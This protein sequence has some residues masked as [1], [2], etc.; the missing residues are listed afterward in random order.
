M[1]VEVYNFN[2]PVYKGVSL[3]W[4]NWNPNFN[5]ECC[6]SIRVLRLPFCEKWV[7]NY[8]TS[9]LPLIRGFPSHGWNDTHHFTVIARQ[10][11]TCEV[12][13]WYTSFHGDCWTNIQVWR[14]SL[15][16]KWILNHTTL[17]FPF[18]KGLPSHGWNDTPLWN[19]TQPLTMIAGQVHE[20]ESFYFPK[21]EC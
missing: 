12:F 3:P 6:L 9:G 7:L 17:G 8:T 21:S 10:V 16:D 13:Q 14:F 2:V 19:D 5:D 11:Y 18:I 20:C 1:S 4:M 15:S